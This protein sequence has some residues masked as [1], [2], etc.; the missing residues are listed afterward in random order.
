MGQSKEG[1]GDCINNVEFTYDY[2]CVKLAQHLK[3][4]QVVDFK[5]LLRVR[6]Q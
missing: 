4:S 3:E 6:T 1:W 5:V 2:T